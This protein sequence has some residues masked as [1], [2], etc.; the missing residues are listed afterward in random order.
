[1]IEIVAASVLVLVATLL[2]LWWARATRRGT[3]PRNWLLGY[4]TPLTLS[5][6]DAWTTV[7]RASAPFA[8]TGGIGAGISALAALVLAVFGG[9]AVAP[10][11]LG[12]GTAWLL[13]WTVLGIIP[14]HRAA[15]R[16]RLRR[17]PA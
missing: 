13:L 8:L 5:D 1:M 15:R 17:P 9:G 11:F 4:R 3:L 12:V 10:A 2:T 14:A 6:E 16:Y 7:N